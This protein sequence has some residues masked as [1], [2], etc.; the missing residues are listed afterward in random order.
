MDVRDVLLS[1]V[2]VFSAS[3]LVYKWLSLYNKVDVGVIF[4]ASLLVLSLALLLLS[5]EY[6]MKKIVE[7]IQSVKRVVMVNSDVLESRLDAR[8]SAM[9]E[10]LEE[11]IEA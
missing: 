4:L 1:A 11:K 3:A 10:K 9:V 2:M 5:I 8:F 7:E 6:R